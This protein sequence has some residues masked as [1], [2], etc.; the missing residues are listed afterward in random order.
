MKN[1]QHNLE[2]SSPYIYPEPISL[3]RTT[4]IGLAKWK[5]IENPLLRSGLAV[6]GA[7]TW[8]KGGKLPIEAEDGI[9]TAEDLAGMDL[10]KTE[11]SSTL[12]L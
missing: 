7:N 10:S 1:Q 11:L 2:T 8:A 9:L 6:A 3:Q 4:T 5:K 12:S